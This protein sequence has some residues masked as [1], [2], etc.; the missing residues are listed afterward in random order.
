MLKI[1]HRH[2]KKKVDELPFAIIVTGGDPFLD[3]DKIN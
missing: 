2:L 3:K 1:C